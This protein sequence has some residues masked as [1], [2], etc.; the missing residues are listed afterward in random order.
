M[1]WK[2]GRRSSNL[3]DRR[4]RGGIRAGRGRKA[5]G[6]GIGLIVLAL[7]AM[8][9]GIDPRMVMQIGG[10]LDGGGTQISTQP[11]EDQS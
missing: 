7:V 9:F 4:R 2:T 8:F 6:G 1:R 3:D 10:A 5:A 11:V